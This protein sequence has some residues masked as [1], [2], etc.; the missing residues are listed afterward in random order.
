MARS[1]IHLNGNK[2]CAIDLETTGDIPGYHDIW[3]ICILPL[4]EK[5]EPDKNFVPYN[6]DLICK[7]PE[8]I[9]ETAIKNKGRFLK[10][11]I[12][13]I[14]PWYALDL[15]DEWFLKLKLGFKKMI[16]PLAQNWVFDRSFLFEWMGKETFNQYLDS[17]FRDCMSTALYLNDVADF[18]AEQTP[19]P[20]V[21]LAYLCSQMKIDHERAHDAFEDCIVTA[22]VYKLLVMKRFNGGAL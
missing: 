16:S 18:E 17:R 20:K 22:Q 12:S 13:G 14:D 9:D 19:F 1:M 7:R 3:Q 21:N 15:L 11:Q 4:D 6:L 10:S 2:L 5:L 8:N